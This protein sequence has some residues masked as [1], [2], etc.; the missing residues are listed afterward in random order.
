[1]SRAE[2]IEIL[3]RA[4][5]DGRICITLDADFHSLPAISGERKPSVIRAPSLDAERDTGG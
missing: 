3:E 2:D 5:T 4:R 1:M